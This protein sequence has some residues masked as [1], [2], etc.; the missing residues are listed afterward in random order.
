[1]YSFELQDRCV[2]RIYYEIYIVWL[3]RATSKIFGK[4]KGALF[5][6]SY[7]YTHTAL[8]MAV[9]MNKSGIFVIRGFAYPFDQTR[10]HGARYE[11][12]VRISK[13]ASHVWH[14]WVALWCGRPVAGSSLL[15]TPTCLHLQGL[16][17]TQ[18]LQ[19]WIE[20]SVHKF[21]S[22][23]HVKRVLCTITVVS[24]NTC[25]C[26]LNPGPCRCNVAPSPHTFIEHVKRYSG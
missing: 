21:G 3:T 26:G 19:Q 5:A 25:I 1:M 9:N 6:Q 16:K 2:W 17:R 15:H 20:G 4:L 18:H 24:M 23:Q 13:C 8:R 11:H 22:P 12:R 7:I 10:W 14:T